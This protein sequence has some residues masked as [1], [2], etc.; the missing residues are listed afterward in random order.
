MT[1]PT[2][3]AEQAELFARSAQM[4]NPKRLLERLATELR[5]LEIENEAL[6]E[7]KTM[8]VKR[9]AIVL[10]Q[11]ERIAELDNI[12]SQ[13]YK[14]IKPIEDWYGFNEHRPFHEALADVV[15]DLQHDRQEALKC[16]QQQARIAELEREVKYRDEIIGL[17]PDGDRHADLV[18][19]IERLK[20][21]IAIYQPELSEKD[22]AALDS[23]PDDLV[24]RLWNGEQ[25][26]SLNQCYVPT[27][28]TMTETEKKPTPGEL[29]DSKIVRLILDEF[30]LLGRGCNATVTTIRVLEKAATELRRLES[31]IAELE[32]K[33]T[34]VLY[35]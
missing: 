13:A 8:L 35:D 9:N 7:I 20:A 22:L 14:A 34:H 11:H 2:M 19:E 18:R 31:R 26:D 33:A 4:M 5:R 6:H 23:L 15:S 30:E 27:S 24:S 28:H 29:S 25:W 17:S 3:L 21:E 12:R 32:A 10:E 16:K 1:K